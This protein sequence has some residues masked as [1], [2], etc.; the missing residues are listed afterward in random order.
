ME[1]TSCLGGQYAKRALLSVVVLMTLFSSASQA[2]LAV[3]KACV[4]PVVF[5]YPEGG[6]DEQEHGTFSL[7]SS[8]ELYSHLGEYWT[9]KANPYARVDALDS[10]RN[11]V[12]LKELD[13]EYFNDG[14]IV[15]LGIRRVSWSTVEA[16]NVLPL[17]IAD[18]I[19]QRDIAGDP[20][21]Q[22]KLGAPSVRYAFQRESLQFEL[23]YL[24]WFRERTLPSRESRENF[25]RGLVKLD[26]DDASF[27]DDDDNRRPAV[28]ARVE[29]ITDAA[30]FALLHYNGYRLDPL[31]VPAAP[32]RL[33]PLY[34]LVN[35]T[36]FTEQ[37]SVGSW[38]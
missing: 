36:A 22:E 12:D 25:T 3:T 10:L 28:A 9:F 27:T 6:S 37:A 35:T 2:D 24:P 15:N 29:W 17:Q 16:V 38:L 19:N 7:A 13:F 26:E 32:A 8:V 30:N 11:L 34:Y 1:Q 4:E 5:Y 18:V 33:R 21:G 20:A 23:Y 14:H 31:F